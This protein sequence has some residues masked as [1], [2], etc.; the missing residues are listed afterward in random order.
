MQ[1]RSSIVGGLIMIL[2][3]AF[4]LLLQ[5]SPTL[6][7]QIDF[8]RQWPLFI[9]GLGIFF[10]LSALLGTPPLAIPGSVM[11]GLGVILYYQNA[12]GDW[13]SWSYIWTLI[14]GFV[15]IGTIVM[16]ILGRKGKHNMREGLRLIT[17]SLVMFVVFW[18]FFHGLGMIGRFWPVLLIMVGVWLL[19]QRRRS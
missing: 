11:T 19:T 7:G 1:K 14:P 8:T 17:V 18:A 9:M 10:L 5:F 4:F 16:G 13:A 6:A 15:G 12:T 2:V 3:G